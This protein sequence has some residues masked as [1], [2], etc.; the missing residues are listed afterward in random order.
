MKP[1]PYS[2]NRPM[3]VLGPQSFSRQSLRASKSTV[4]HRPFFA[5]RHELAAR[6]RDANHRR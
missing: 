1:Q 6:A 4:E 5:H 2:T 3:V